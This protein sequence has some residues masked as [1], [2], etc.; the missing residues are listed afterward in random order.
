M[1]LKLGMKHGEE[2][3]KVYNNHEPGMTLAYFMTRSTWVAHV[4]EWGKIAKISFEGK[5]LNEIG[6]RTEDL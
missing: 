1:I 2:L 3:Q 5:N 6:K 4:F